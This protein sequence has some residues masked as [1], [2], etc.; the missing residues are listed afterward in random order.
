[1]TG[2]IE[3]RRH[4]MELRPRVTPVGCAV[5]ALQLIAQHQHPCQRV[6]LHPQRRFAFFGL[7]VLVEG[8]CKLEQAVVE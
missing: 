2:E 4:G 3:V 8:D 5:P 7:F 1:M 6:Q